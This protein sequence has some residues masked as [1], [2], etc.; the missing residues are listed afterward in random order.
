M[1]TRLLALVVAAVVGMATVAVIG[2][3]Q[4]RQTIEQE[5][6][7]TAQAAVQ[8]ALG[9]VAS[10]GAREQA[11]ELTRAAA[12]QA[13]TAA[14]R[15]LRYSGE[16]YFWV[17]DMTPTMVMHPIKPEMDGTDLSR[18]EDPTGARLFV[19]MVDVVEREG[20]GFV[21]YL[22]PKPGEEDPQPKVSFVAGYE[23]WGWVVG[24][25][26][27]VADLDGAF[28]A[29][30]LDMALWALPV[31]LAIVLLSLLVTRTITRP[32]REMTDV[33]AAGD[34]RRRLP[35]RGTGDELDGLATALNATLSDVSDV[36]AG[37]SRAS[38]LLERSAQT[39][40]ATSETIAG[41]AER[42]TGQAQSVSIA[43]AEVSG[44]IETV[45]AGAEQMGTSIREIS[46]NA[47]E[48]ARVAAQAVTEAEATTSTIT[49]L[50]DSSREIGDVVKVITSIAEQTNLLALNATIEAARAGE[51]GKGFAV[52]ANE[53]KE[54]AQETA[55]AT[56][57]IA[58]RVEAIQGD[59][60][61]AVAAIGRISEVIGRINDFQLTIAS[62][63]EEQTATTAEMTRSIS[64]AAGSGRSIATTVAEVARGAQETSAGI[65]AM[66][67]AAAGL[68]RTS[69]ELQ[70]S[71]AAF[72]Q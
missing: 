66:Q 63:V 51:A 47:T 3:L 41:T 24:S 56:E 9:V 59:T 67:A 16:E 36:V 45:A 7:Q 53:V 39:V 58:R 49:R 22:W 37:V 19:E 29:E 11:G 72:Q 61:G 68:V 34:L 52:V 13:A 38:R 10:Y 50:G 57:D 12:Q 25:G 33:L 69:Q 62:A 42:S 2:A 1:G 65:G 20:S 27:Y 30:L 43:A 44:G 71:V 8:T 70:R 35:A 17:N 48:A 60:S 4:V 54:L 55:K 23:P 40:S 15:E 5:Q 32:L 64:E 28:R 26:L 6:R 18:T 31:V 14:L 21:S 46:Q